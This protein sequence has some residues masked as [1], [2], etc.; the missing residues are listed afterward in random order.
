MARRHW[1]RLGMALAGLAVGTDRDADGDGVYGVDWGH[2]WKALL[3]LAGLGLVFGTLA[4]G[5]GAT[6]AVWAMVDAVLGGTERRSHTGARFPSSRRAC[7]LQPTSMRHGSAK[8]ASKRLEASA[9]TKPL[10]SASTCAGPI[11][12][13]R[14]PKALPVAV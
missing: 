9:H 13:G 6:A 14:W 10:R 1:R 2:T 4:L 7:M 11:S 3:A 5:F 8:L 12:P